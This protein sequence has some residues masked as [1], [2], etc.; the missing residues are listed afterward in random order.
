MDRLHKIA[1]SPASSTELANSS[2]RKLSSYRGLRAIEF[3]L[4][5]ATADREFIDGRQELAIQEIARRPD[6][7]ATHRLAMLLQP[8]NGLARREAVAS[9]LEQNACDENCIQSVLHYL[10]RYWCGL[11]KW[12]DI[13]SVGGESGYAELKKEQEQLAERLR[14]VLAKNQKATLQVLH[15]IYGLGSPQP[16]AFSLHIVETLN[17]RGACPLLATSERTLLDASKAEKLKSL[18][19]DLRCPSESGTAP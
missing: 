5:I 16:S 15:V 6:S 8:F 11:G 18:Q 9:A 4:Q 2:V 13:P 19:R 3:L 1:L 17:L 14:K 12:E 10:E 7:D